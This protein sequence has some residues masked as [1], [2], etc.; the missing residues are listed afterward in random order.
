VLVKSYSAFKT[1]DYIIIIQS[2]CKMTK[3]YF[4]GFAESAP[5]P[6][7]DLDAKKFKKRGD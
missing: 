6:D 5:S 3:L 4:N 7:T 1:F 2:V